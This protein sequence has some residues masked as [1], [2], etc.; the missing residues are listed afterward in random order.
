METQ[1]FY[2]GSGKTITSPKFADQSVSLINIGVNIDQIK[3]L[4]K[5]AEAEQSKYVK[6]KLK[7]RKE[8]DKYGNDWSLME[9]DWKPSGETY[10]KP[11]PSFEDDMPDIFN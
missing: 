10:D 5:K 1:V 4:I 8:A 7:K 11:K 6:L 2:C 3:E 9:N